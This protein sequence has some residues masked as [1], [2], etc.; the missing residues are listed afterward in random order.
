MGEGH[1][2]STV[3]GTSKSTLHRHAITDAISTM[4]FL[5]NASS[6]YSFILVQPIGA[7]TLQLLV[8]RY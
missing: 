2:T 3:A 4:L 6:S 5:A 7:S 1:G 8:H